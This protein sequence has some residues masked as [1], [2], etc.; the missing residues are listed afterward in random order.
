VQ[1]LENVKR[2]GLSA[3]GR[4]R[5]SAPKAPLPTIATFFPVG[6]AFTMVVMSKCCLLIVGD[7]T[8]E[9][10]D[11]ERFAFFLQQASAF[12]VIFLRAD[13][14]GDCRQ[15]IVFANLRCRGHEVTGHD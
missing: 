3:P 12:A 6:G 10:S 13:A 7:E 14:S 8:L 9:I 11:A 2:R 15:Y 5:R 4:P 1:C